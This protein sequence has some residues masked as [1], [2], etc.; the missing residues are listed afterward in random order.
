MAGCPAIHP[1]AARVHRAR[2]GSAAHLEVKDDDAFVHL[3]QHVT[4]GVA[5]QIDRGGCYAFSAGDEGLWP[6]NVAANQAI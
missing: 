5:G 6:I 4:L 2:V 3:A 1:L